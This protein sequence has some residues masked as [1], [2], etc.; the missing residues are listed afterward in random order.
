M[1]RLIIS[2]SMLALFFLAGAG[3]SEGTSWLYLI[4][5]GKGDKCYLDIDSIKRTSTDTMQV[6]RK[7][8]PHKSE[9]VSSLVSHLEVDCKGSRI[10]LLRE[11]TNFT[12]GESRT[13]KGKPRFQSAGPEDIEESLVEFVCSLKKAR[14]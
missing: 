9:E 1:S 2:A 3:L 10:K 5:N 4:E 6:V 8:E 14:Q 13:I 7:I 11:I 12:N